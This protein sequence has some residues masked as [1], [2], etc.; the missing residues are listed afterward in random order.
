MGFG[1]LVGV[2]IGFRVLGFQDLRNSLGFSV[3][4]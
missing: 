2:R 3:W 4:G 1:S